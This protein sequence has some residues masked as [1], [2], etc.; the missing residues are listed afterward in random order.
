MKILLI[1]WGSVIWNLSLF[2]WSFSGKR[3]F[4]QAWWPSVEMETQTSIARVCVN[5]HFSASYGN[6]IDW[7]FASHFYLYSLLNYSRGRSTV[8]L[9]DLN[10]VSVRKKVSYSKNAGKCFQKL[11]KSPQGSEKPIKSW[12]GPN[13]W[14]HAATFSTEQMSD[15]ALSINIMQLYRTFSQVFLAV[16]YWLICVF[17]KIWLR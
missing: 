1:D 14:A 6:S 15:N 4:F 5:I 12:T 8:I 17:T 9:L 10:C 3:F 13:I 16:I 11:Q 7:L 2:K